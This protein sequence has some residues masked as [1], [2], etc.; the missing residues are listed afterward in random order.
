MISINKKLVVTALTAVIL[1]ACGGSS[2]SSKEMV[3]EVPEPEPVAMITYSYQVKITN[4]TYSQ[5][6]S[7][8]IAVVV[9]LRCRLLLFH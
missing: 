8:K 9:V 2:S 3:V 4:L 6:M 7:P 1:S 5:P